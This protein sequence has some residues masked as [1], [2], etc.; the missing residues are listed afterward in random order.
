[1]SKFAQLKTLIASAET[2][3]DKFFNK[4]NGAA[5]TR[6]RKALQEAKSLAQ[7]IRNEVTAIKNKGK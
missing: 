7:D 2:D 5:G 3:A 6:L 4:G 1:M